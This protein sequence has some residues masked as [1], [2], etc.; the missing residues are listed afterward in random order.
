MMKKMNDGYRLIVD[1]KFAGWNLKSPPRQ[2]YIISWS[3][4]AVIIVVKAIFNA[5]S[6]DQELHDEN[7]T[8]EGTLC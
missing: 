8:M 3:I 6:Y 5:D 7:I 2:T 1:K 4:E